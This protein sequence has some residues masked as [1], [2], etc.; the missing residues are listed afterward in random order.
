MMTDGFITYSDVSASIYC[1]LI[2]YRFKALAACKEIKCI[3][4]QRLLLLGDKC[5]DKCCGT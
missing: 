4:L 3:S 1:A 5:Y 2:S